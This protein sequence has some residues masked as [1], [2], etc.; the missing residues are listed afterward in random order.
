[1]PT[2]PLAASGCSWFCLLSP[3]EMADKRKKGECYFC[4][5]KFLHQ[6]KCNMKGVFLMKLNDVDDPMSLVDELGMSLHTLTDIS[7]MHLRA[8]VDSGST[9]TFIDDEVVHCLGLGLTYQPG[10]SVKVANGE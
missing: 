2:A 3:E 1:L 9:H 4:P 8:L 7:T 5:E 10:L 6:H